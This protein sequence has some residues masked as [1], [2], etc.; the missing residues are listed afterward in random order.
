[1]L[2][3]AVHGA[4]AAVIAEAQGELNSLFGGDADAHQAVVQQLLAQ[5]MAARQ[6][7]RKRL[8]LYIPGR[9]HH[10]VVMIRQVPRPR[11]PR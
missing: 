6:Q 7:G 5:F 11:A 10:P 4:D 2:G 1:V 3:S 9:R 8:V